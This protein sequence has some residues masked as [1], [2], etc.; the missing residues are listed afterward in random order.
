MEE[1]LEEAGQEEQQGKVE[2]VWKRKRRMMMMIIQ[3]LS[4]LDHLSSEITD[5]RSKESEGRQD[6]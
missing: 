4:V 1:G 6:L 3:R 2:E 5:L